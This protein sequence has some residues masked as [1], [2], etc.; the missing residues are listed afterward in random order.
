MINSLLK[1]DFVYIQVFENKIEVRN[2]DGTGR[3]VSNNSDQPFSS[4]R[5][6]VGY[7][8]LAENLIKNSIIEVVDKRLLR[9]SI[10]GIIH[11]KDKCEGGYSE[12]EERVLRELAYGAGC[13]KVKIWYGYDLS[14]EEIIEKFASK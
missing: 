5:S 10:F 11:G 2:C 14:D 13:S 8:A 12:V 6:L 4:S 7:F 9:K 3:V 1:P